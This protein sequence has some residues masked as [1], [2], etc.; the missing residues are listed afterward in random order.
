[1]KCLRHM[2]NH[3]SK[4]L[5]NMHNHSSKCLGYMHNHIIIPR[6]AF[7]LDAIR[8]FFPCMMLGSI[9]SVK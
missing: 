6:I 4:C 7:S 2:H 8:T 5:R 1:M 3:F 9:V